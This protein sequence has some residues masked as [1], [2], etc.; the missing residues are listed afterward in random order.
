M[1][2]CFISHGGYDVDII[3][4]LYAPDLKRFEIWGIK[5]NEGIKFSQP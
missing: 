1:M 3:Q 4:R 5:G 2:L